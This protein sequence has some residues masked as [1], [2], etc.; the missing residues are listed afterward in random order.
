MFMLGVGGFGVTSLFCALA[1][2]IELL[3]LARALQGV[4]GALL[5]PAALAGDHVHLPARRA[6][7]GDRG[8]DRMGRHRNRARPADRRPA[9]WSASWRWIFAINIRSCDHAGARH[10]RDGAG[11]PRPADARVDYVG[12]FCARSGSPGSRTG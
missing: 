8:V 4:F 11:R 7:E 2:T 6:R 10:A 9:R 3:V 12:R 5:T 1:P